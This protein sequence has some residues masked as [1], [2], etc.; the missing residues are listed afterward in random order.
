MGLKL[1]KDMKFRIFCEEREL[2]W[3]PN[4]FGYTDKI[5]EAGKYSFG[6]AE[7]I[8]SQINEHRTK[9]LIS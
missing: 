1:R 9:H 7:H 3:K 8:C 6:E 5:E 4:S 2:W